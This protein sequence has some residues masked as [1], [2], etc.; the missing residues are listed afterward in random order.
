MKLTAKQKS[1]CLEYIIDFNATQAAI[2]AGYSERTA[3]RIASENLSKLDI[4]NC[5]AKLRESKEQDLIASADEVLQRLTGIL[6]GTVKEQVIV[7]VDEKSGALKPKI[8]EKAAG[9]KE[10]LKAA[11][12]LGKYHVIFKER[13]INEFSGGDFVL[14]IKN[15]SDDFGP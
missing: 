2:R 10:Q 8:V 7:G 15:E 6:R 13:V 1:F 3:N 5:I 14:E 4:Q 12:M 11:E 9:F